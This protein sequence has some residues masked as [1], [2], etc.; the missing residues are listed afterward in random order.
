MMRKITVLAICAVLFAL[1]VSAEARQPGKIPRVGF[2]SPGYGKNPMIDA[3]RRG[4]RE[5]GWVEG[6]NIAVEYRW[7]EGNEDRL[8]TLAN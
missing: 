3:F 5:L 7:G 8:P 6:Q 1:C 2:L 4:L